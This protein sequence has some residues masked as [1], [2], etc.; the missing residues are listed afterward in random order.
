MVI[1]F[2]SFPT[3]LVINTIEQEV[4]NIESAAYEVIE[5]GTPYNS[6]DHG[7][8][9][10]DLP[11]HILVSDEPADTTGFVRKRTWASNRIDEDLYN[12]Q[13][14]YEGNNPDY[15][16]YSRTYILPRDGYT[17]LPALSPD[18]IDESAKLVSESLTN[19]VQPAELGN[20]YV[21]VV[22]YIILFL[23]RLL[24]LLSILMVKYKFPRLLP[25]RK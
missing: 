24:S 7:V 12:F 19:E 11:D 3:P 13:I 4:I 16:I 23:V 17:P 1:L 14:D 5:Y 9:P 22:R 10:K 15:P 20:Q 21:K 25:F 6:V 18:P 2:P 8:N